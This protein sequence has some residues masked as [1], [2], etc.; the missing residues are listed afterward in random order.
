[1][2]H[3]KIYE[4]LLNRRVELRAL[5]FLGVIVVLFTIFLVWKMMLPIKIPCPVDQS[6]AQCQQRLDREFGGSVYE[7]VY[8]PQTGLAR[9]EKI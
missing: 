8:Y 1:M 7:V 4:E 2:Y 3:S 9:G 5:R 6:P